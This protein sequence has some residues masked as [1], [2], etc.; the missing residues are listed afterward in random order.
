MDDDQND[1]CF[2]QQLMQYLSDEFEVTECE[3]GEI[4]MCES[5][6]ERCLMNVPESTKP[7]ADNLC[8]FAGISENEC[9]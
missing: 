2:E 9:N 7:F 4:P 6:I 8:S 1:V 3:D 5:E